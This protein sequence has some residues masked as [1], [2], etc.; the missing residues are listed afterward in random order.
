MAMTIDDAAGILK[1]RYPAKKLQYIGYKNN[2]LLALLPKDP[3]FD[4][5]VYDC[6]LWYGGNQGGSHT[7]SKA[8]ANKTGGLYGSFLLTRN[9]D[10]ALTSV[11]TEAV[12]ASMSDV[13]AFLKLSTAEVDNTVRMAAQN[14]NRDLFGNTG[15]ARGRVGGVVTTV[16][17]LKD[18]N[19]VVNFEQGM[20]IT[21][22]NTDGT[23]G[24][25]DGEAITITKVDYNSGKLT[26]AVTWT[27]GG[28]F[29]NDDY[30][31]REGD[32]GK[33]LA[34]LDTYLPSAAP[35]GTLFGQDRSVN[36]RLGG[37]R[38]DG[39]A[40]NIDEA[41]LAADVLAAREGA[42]L[43]HYFM[44]HVDFQ[45]LRVALGSKIIYDKVASPDM[46][47]VGFRSIVI[48]GVEGDIQVVADRKCPTNVAYGLQMD[49]WVFASLGPAPRF[50]A[51]MGQDSVI[52]DYNADSVEFRSGYYGQLGCYA[53][54]LN[55]RVALPSS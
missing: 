52:W 34:G 41:L 44:N 31:F 32:F 37:M 2:P 43:T 42:K 15:G 38:Y 8:Q 9:A 27:A 51:A 39:S 19:T 17:T 3:T 12:L 16:L 13:G 6:P 20:K 11:P 10:Y 53:P 36:S 47:S 46:A 25:D 22:S 48:S 5:K 18:I 14:L 26:A 23:S 4:G 21:S 33:G 24:S 49:S 55:I 50:L 29:S 35:T 30:L 1:Q 45:N 54:G 28:N 40:Q 7:F